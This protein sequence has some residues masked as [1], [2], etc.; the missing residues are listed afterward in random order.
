MYAKSGRAKYA[1][2]QDKFL[3]FIFFITTTVSCFIFN[4]GVDSFVAINAGGCWRKL[5]IIVIVSEL[6]VNIRC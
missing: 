3:Y 1:Q 6:Q 2:Q 5:L 4:N